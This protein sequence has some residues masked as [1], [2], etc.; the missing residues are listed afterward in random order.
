MSIV[1]NSD[2]VGKYEITLNQYNVDLIDLY[3][4]KYE[5]HY[6]LKMLGATLYNLFIDDLTGTPE[7]PVTAIYTTIF[8][9]FEIDDANWSNQIL[10]SNG[11]KEMLTGFI[12]YHL[13]LD[14]QQI[15]TSIGVTSPNAENST[16]I[17]MNSITNSRYND[18]VETFQ[19]IQEYI[20]LHLSD[21]PTYNGQELKI[22][23]HL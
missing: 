11:I 12:Y 1:L 4:A 18:N 2:F 7:V 19:A 6:L 9:P 8:E 22:N 21:Y 15:Q 13:T 10:I 5:K 16:I 3:I 17:A 23:Y 14:N 20:E